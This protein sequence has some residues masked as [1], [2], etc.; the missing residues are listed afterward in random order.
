MR[1]FSIVGWSGN[2]KTMLITRL[3]QDFKAKGRRVIAVKSTHGAYDLQPAGK[4]TARF[5]QAGAEEAYLLTDKEMLR[6][7]TLASP[8]ALLAELEARLAP[9]DIVLLEGLTRPG[10]PV[11][12][13]EDPEKKKPLKTRPEALAAV[14]GSGKSGMD[15]KA[16]FHAGDIAAIGRFME[17]THG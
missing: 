5:L 1:I 15:G 3:I 10:I 14:V 16:V 9:D 2:G 8:D 11:I 6:M 12:E 13:V 4:D 17:E 7:T